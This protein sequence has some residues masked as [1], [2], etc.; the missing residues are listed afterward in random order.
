MNTEKYLEAL[1]SALC[2]LYQLNDAAPEQTFEAMSELCYILRLG[3]AEA[4]IY[5]NEADE[6]RG[7]YEANCFYDCGKANETVG[8][9]KRVA[10]ADGKVIRYN[11]YSIK[12]EAEWTEEEK[13]RINTF[14]VVLSTFVG[15][16]RLLNLVQYL[17]FHERDFGM[18]NLNQF[19]KCVHTL[20]RS[21]RILEYT[22]V[23]FNLKHFSVVNQHLGRDCGTIV[24]KK[25]IKLIDE[26]L[27]D[28]ELICRIGGDNF[29]TL[30]KNDKLQSV[31]DILS[32]V[33]IVYDENS[34]ERVFI[35]AT[36]GVYVIKNLEGVIP[37]DVMDRVSLAAYLAR[38]SSTE[39]VVYF[40]DALYA[41]KNR[42]ND[43][44]A[45]FPKA[46]EDREFVAYYQPKFAV[47]DGHIAGA[48][49]LCRWVHNGQLI[50]P[51]DFIP[52]L[53]RGHDI[54]KLDFYMLDAVCRDIRRWLDNG[55]KV[56]RISVNFSRRHLSDVDLLE[57]IIEVVDKYGI[58]HEYIEIEL[59]ETTTDVEFKDLKRIIRGLQKEGI[60]T[61]VDDFGM[62]YSSLNLIKEIPWNVLKL[63]RSLLPSE[64]D[65]NPVQK[66][67][68]FKYI[69][70]MA[71][72]MGLECISEGV[73]TKEQ[74]Q[75]LV[76][77]KCN[78]AQGFYFERPLPV[79]EFE[80]RLNK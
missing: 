13:K 43:I 29:L 79:E 22:A 50:P 24:M 75:I 17:T 8:I 18:Y 52:V 53:E 21:G 55:M 64:G 58:P 62:G 57:H 77:N 42:N 37:T 71:Q 28:E 73:E 1:E 33:R 44:S 10:V 61:S 67:I 41:K 68:M 66:S 15:K 30:I 38:D 45:R 36:V 5:E 32:G 69:I 12:G 34:N 78:L 48:E 19:M 16:T 6:Y 35:T 49:A 14:I 20:F 63:D 72:E 51:G 23:R 59:T 54:C 39:D 4:V 27:D 40:D 60:Y 9:S 47:N 46:L 70:A 65:E 80:K 26:L 7:V 11:I 3:K 74:L 2:K 56:V 76:D 25:F 31:L